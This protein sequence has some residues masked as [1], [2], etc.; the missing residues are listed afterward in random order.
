MLLKKKVLL[1]YTNFFNPSKGGYR[2]CVDH[3]PKE[4]T[5]CC[6]WIFTEMLLKWPCFSPANNLFVEADALWRVRALHEKRWAV[7]KFSDWPGQSKWGDHPYHPTLFFTQWQPAV[8]RAEGN[9]CTVAERRKTVL[10]NVK[11]HLQIYISEN[12]LTKLQNTFTFTD[13]N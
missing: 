7:T 8:T 13:T 2:L 5:L 11:T 9:E 4:T 12:I 6:R 1:L 3:S 10:Q